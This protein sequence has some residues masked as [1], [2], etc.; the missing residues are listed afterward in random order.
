MDLYLIPGLGADHRLFDRLALP[1][2]TLHYLDWPRMPEHASLRQFAQELAHKIDRSRPHGLLGVSMGG[3]VAQELAAITD[4]KCVVLISSWKG[5]SEMPWNIRMMRGLRPERMVTDV[6]VRRVVPFLRILRWTLGME[7]RASQ[8]LGQLML[9]TFSARDL[10]VMMDAVIHWN[11]PTS[12][13]KKLV[14]IHGDKDRLMPI[15]LIKEP[16]VVP[17]GTHFMVYSRAEEVSAAVRRAL[18]DRT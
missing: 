4:P 6:M 11:G 5:R 15:S 17:G 1:E 3:M 8:E 7:D 14:H 10:R 9:S 16:I 13:L 18:L 2:H 12:P